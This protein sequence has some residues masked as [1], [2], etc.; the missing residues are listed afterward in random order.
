MKGF[1][2]ENMYF[3]IDVDLNGNADAGSVTT[4]SMLCNSGKT[5]KQFPRKTFVVPITTFSTEEGI[6]PE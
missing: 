2:F 6:E 4:E 1:F 5:A 3:E